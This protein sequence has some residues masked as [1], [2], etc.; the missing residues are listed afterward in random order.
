MEQLNALRLDIG[1]IVLLAVILIMAIKNIITEFINKKER[2]EFGRR[3]M[4]GSLTEYTE[5]TL[6]LERGK[7]GEVTNEERVKLVDDEMRADRIPV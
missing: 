4:A 1:H 7:R 3:L 2:L 6:A 5:S